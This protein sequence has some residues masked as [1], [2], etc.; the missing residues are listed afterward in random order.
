MS[1]WDDMTKR[2]IDK[3]DILD[4]KIDKLCLWKIE[5]EVEWKNHM[6][7][8][9]DRTKGKERRFYYIIALMGIAF[10][11]QEIIRSVI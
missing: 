7:K 11:V 6:K 4:D 5:M 10:T 2:I 3:L 8:I 9:E 1:E